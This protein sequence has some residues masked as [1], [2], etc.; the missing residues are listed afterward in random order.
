M[1]RPPERIDL[2]A[3]GAALRRHAVADLDA[4]HGA[5]ETSRDHLRPFM[6]WADQG[7]DD[8]QG[9]LERT[10]A[11]WESGEAFGYLVVEG[12]DDGAVLGSGGL[13]RRSAADALEI[14]YWRRVDAPGRGLITELARSL[15]S[16]ALDLPGITRVEIHCDAANTASADV[17]RRL[18]FTFDGL[19]DHTPQAPAETGKHQVWSTTTRV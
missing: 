5:I 15:T 2:P 8:T 18:G 6:V 11:E 7:R 19:I 4:L 14:G 1:D 12:D 3:V 13:H 9:F 17:A 10:V 16:A